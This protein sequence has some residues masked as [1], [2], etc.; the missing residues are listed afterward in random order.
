MKQIIRKVTIAV[1]LFWVCQASGDLRGTGDIGVVIE[2]ET[3]SIQIVNTTKPASMGRIEGLG[4]LSHASVVFSRDQRYAYVFGRDGGLTKIDLLQDKIDKRIIQAGNSIGGAISQ[5]GKVIAVS[6]YTPGGVKLFDAVTLEQLAEIPA[7]Y[8][9]DNKLSKVVGLVDAPGQRFVCSL[10]EGN[11]IWLIDAKNPRQPIVKKFKDIGKQPYDALLTPDGHFYAAGLFGE[12]GLALLDLWQPEKGVEHIL[13]DYGKDDEQMPVYKMPHLEGWTV[14]GDWLLVPAVGLHEVLV[15]DTREWELV[16]R[17]PV[18]GQPV[19]VTSRPDG[20]QVWVNFAF[21]D[22]QTVQVVDLKDFNIVKTLQPG[23]A[24]L[25]ME[26]SPRG[27][28]VWLAVRDEDRVM[29][30]DTETFQ[31]TARLSAQKP[32]GIFFTDRANRIG[33]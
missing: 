12:K 29:V 19:F 17:I 31:E 27:E 2:R 16:K 23:K 1:A 3:G 33:W 10:F 26:F 21:P 18:A 28:S 25:H 30:Y 4:D 8:G 9:E 14:A 32:S 24:V 6:N 5:D 11:E 15:I 20:R 13:E 22:N 7:V